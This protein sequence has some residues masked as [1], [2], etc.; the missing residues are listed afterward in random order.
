MSAPN[1]LSHQ[2]TTST[3]LKQWIL[4]LLAVI[5][6]WTVL[7][8]LLIGH[9]HKNP[10]HPLRFMVVLMWIRFWAS[11]VLVIS[12]FYRIPIKGWHHMQTAKACR[13][14]LIFNHETYID[15][16]VIGALLPPSGVA[17]A[18]IALIPFINRF[19][20]ALQFIFIKRKDT[21]DKH[22]KYTFNGK[23]TVQCISQRASDPRYPL[24]MIAPEATTKALPCILKFKN[25]AFV[26][27]RPV[28]AVLLRY[29]YAHFNPGWGVTRYTFLHV[30][31]LFSQFV[32]HLSVEILPVFVPTPIEEESNPAVFAQ[33]VRR[34][35]AEQLGVPLVEQGLSEQ[36]ELNKLG[37]YPNLLGNKIVFSRGAT[38]M[39]RKK[40]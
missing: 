20:I 34:E 11:F 37:I 1:T 8:L 6:S 27:K 36:R 2:N 3:F 31:R 26:P 10:M 40:E 13:A 4:L 7:N 24:L 29:S 21:H 25:G 39:A 23:D 17:K 15:P 18:G 19:A 33:R 12:G 14:I 35:M 9:N 16:I 32:N 5:Y 38:R 28:V 22:N 30:W